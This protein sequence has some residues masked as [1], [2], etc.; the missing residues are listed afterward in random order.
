MGFLDFFKK[1]ETQEEEKP[2]SQVGNPAAKSIIGKQEK[3]QF[4]TFKFTPVG[5]ERSFKPK[6]RPPAPA[7]FPKYL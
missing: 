1:R 2:A 5:V 7:P 6:D 3:G 4:F